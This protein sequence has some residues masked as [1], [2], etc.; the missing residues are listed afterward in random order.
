MKLGALLKWGDFNK[1]R[2]LLKDGAGSLQWDV[3]TTDKGSWK[4]L[5]KFNLMKSPKYVSWDDSLG[6]CW[7]SLFTDFLQVDSG[8][9]N[10]V[11]DT[12]C[13]GSL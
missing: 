12:A 4:F 3:F 13:H 9:L 8:R 5:Q 1:R 7:S 11:E 10:E 2:N 6:I